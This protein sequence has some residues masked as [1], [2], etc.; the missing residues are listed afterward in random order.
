MPKTRGKMYAHI[1]GLEDFLK[2]MGVAKQNIAEAERVFGQLA[3]TT[4]VAMARSEASGLGRMPSVAAQDL[5]VVGKGT[6]QYG[7]QPFS[8][9]AEFGAIQY[10]Q[11]REWRGN[12]E[13]A[14]YFL[15]PSIRE[16]R[17]QDMLDL[18]AKTVWETMKETF[19][20]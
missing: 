3:A 2:D 9:G 4:V 6:V 7:G 20:G 8:F 14:G 11:F 10:H 15:W 19:A 18:W 16:F 17:D 1:E 5:R 12:Q 13:D